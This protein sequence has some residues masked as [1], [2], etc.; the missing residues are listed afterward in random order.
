[1]ITIDDLKQFVKELEENETNQILK[2]ILE[3]LKQINNKIFPYY[4]TYTYNKPN[5]KT[6]KAYCDDF[7]AKIHL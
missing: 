6:D 2:E 3:Q 7:E 4:T 1:M 5:I